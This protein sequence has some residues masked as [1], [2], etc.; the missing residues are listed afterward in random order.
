MGCT[1]AID[2]FHLFFCFL[3]IVDDSDYFTI[4][5]RHEGHFSSM[6]CRDDFPLDYVGSGFNH[7]RVLLVTQNY[8]SKLKFLDPNLKNKFF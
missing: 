6:R 8:V 4:A 1:F 3:L 5:L 2:M 7:F